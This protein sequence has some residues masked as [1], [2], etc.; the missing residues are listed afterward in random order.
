MSKEFYHVSV[1]LEECIEGLNIKP[2]GICGW[3]PG[4]RRSL[5][6]DR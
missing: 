5:Q 6:P 1:L 4:R 2:D 3:H